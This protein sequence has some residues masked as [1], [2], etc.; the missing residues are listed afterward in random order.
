MATL[1]GCSG[2]QQNLVY[3]HESAFEYKGSI[4]CQIENSGGD[5]ISAYE[6]RANPLAHTA[7]DFPQK[8]LTC[9]Q[10]PWACITFRSGLLQPTYH[11]LDLNSILFSV[12]L[13]TVFTKY[14]P[15]GSYN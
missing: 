12:F 7:A 8:D 4:Q 5:L 6:E 9:L 14:M 2:Y 1:T 11:Y 10:P 15:K 3:S 13:N